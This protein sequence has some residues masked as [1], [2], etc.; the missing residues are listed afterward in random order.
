[1]TA[2]LQWQEVRVVPA[3]RNRVRG[4]LGANGNDRSRQRE[5]ASKLD[6]S[7]ISC[8]DEV[9][10]DE[11]APDPIVAHFVV[12]GH[13][14]KLFCGTFPLVPPL[15]R[16]LGGFLDR[17]IPPNPLFIRGN[18]KDHAMSGQS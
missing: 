15:Q 18:S 14:G 11:N 7:R 5:R 2:L 1:M 9:D 16:R 12:V 10:S 6:S 8:R 4:L 3:G 13:A 17:K